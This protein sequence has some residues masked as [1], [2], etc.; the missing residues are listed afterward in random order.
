MRKEKYGDFLN[1]LVNLTESLLKYNGITYHS[2]EGRLK[3]RE[4]L[5]GKI[6]RKN[7]YNDIDEITDIVGIRI[8]TY[9]ED[10][11]AVVEKMIKEE[12]EIDYEKSV[13][14]R[15][16][17]LNEFG[18]NSLHLIASLNSNR[19]NLIEYVDFKKIQFEFQVRT[20]LQHA[21]AEVEHDIG[22]KSSNSEELP[23]EIKRGFYRLS[24]LL[25]IADNYF[26]ELL[27]SIKK[28][29]DQSNKLMSNLSEGEVVP[30]NILTLK[31]Y[32]DNN[33]IIKELGEYMI[34]KFNSPEIKTSE[35]NVENYLNILKFFKIENIN[36]LNNLL[37]TH[38]EDMIKVIDYWA[39]QQKETEIGAEAN[40][41]N[42]LYYLSYV[43][44]IENESEDQFEKYFDEL[45][46]YRN[47]EKTLETYYYEL[48]EILD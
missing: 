5:D 13:D 2:V 31:S 26:V 7:K 11:I 46:I 22:Y 35:D 29:E 12:F 48:K 45:N 15:K 32:I 41:G 8:I 23:D 39:N 18:Y 17:N 21:W 43:L 28:S 16:K 33:D 40:I 36:Q 38:K 30:T 6:S 44:L 9:T 25:E 37:I 34:N 42:C 4:S 27:K 14:K 3:T 20:I 47:M 24:S 1:Q 19:S 10:I